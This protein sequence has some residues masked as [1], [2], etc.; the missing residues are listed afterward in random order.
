MSSGKRLLLFLLLTLIV[1]GLAAQEEI[2][3]LG[4]T[5]TIKVKLFPTVPSGAKKGLAKYMY[6]PS[7]GWQIVT[8]AALEV[9]GLYEI[10]RTT[11]HYKYNYI[12]AIYAKFIQL[13]ELA[14]EK[15]AFDK[16][17]S[18][19]SQARDDFEKYYNK[20]INSFSALTISSSASAGK[21]HVR[22]VIPIAITLQI[23]LVYIPETTEQILQSLEYFKQTINSEQ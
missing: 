9:P 2:P 5:K 11:R 4:T 6:N 15:N 12:S 13:L 16:Y 19:I 8:V 7:A 10:T 18:R 17:G 3:L 23:T 14:A 22:K 1:H 20:S 21:Q